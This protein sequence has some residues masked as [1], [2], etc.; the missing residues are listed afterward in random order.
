MEGKETELAKA[1]LDDQLET[2]ERLLAQ[3]VSA[4]AKDENGNPAL[5]LAAEGGH[6]DALKLLHKH[7]ANLDAADSIGGT[8]LMNA[9]INGRA[10]CAET[11]LEWGADKDA[12]D[13]DGWTA[14]HCAA[15][16]G[17]LECARLLVAARAD[18]AKKNSDG[19][20]ALELAWEE[21]KHKRE[22]VKVMEQADANVSCGTADSQPGVEDKVTEATRPKKRR[23][24]SRTSSVKGAC[25]SPCVVRLCTL[26]R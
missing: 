13:S 19:D 10:D 15:K 6:L 12:V 22:V 18:R 23:V 20:T 14:L 11:L 8:A 4:E 16:Y 7:G 21:D 24:A 17:R 5:A 3:G 25:V 2:M 9:V 1:A 26:R